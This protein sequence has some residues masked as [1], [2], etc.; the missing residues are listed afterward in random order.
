MKVLKVNTLMRPDC[1]KKAY[2]RLAKDCDAL[3]V[4]NRIGI[5]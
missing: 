5:I 4:A 1:Q 2:V 3:D